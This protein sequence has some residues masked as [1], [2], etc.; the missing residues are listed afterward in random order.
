MRKANRIS[1]NTLAVIIGLVI[2]VWWIFMGLNAGFRFVS[3][4][5]ISYM[6]TLGEQRHTIMTILALI[7][8]PICARENKWGFLSAMVLGIVTLALS[9]IHSIYMLIATP[10]GFESQI[11]GPI[12][13][14]VIQ[15]PIIIFSYKA[16]Q[17]LIIAINKE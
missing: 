11:F 2:S 16:R 17:E 5:Q 9:S 15:I 10:L 4:D 6:L 1:N 14:S 7:L 13:W 8:I 3:A 12:I